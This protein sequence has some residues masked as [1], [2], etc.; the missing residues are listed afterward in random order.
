MKKLLSI[1]LSMVCVFVGVCFSGCEKTGPIPNGKYADTPS[2][3]ISYYTEDHG[4]EFYWEVKGDEAWH[5]T[6]NSLDYKAE[7]EKGENGEI[8]FRGYKWKSFLS[9]TQIG[10]ET[11]YVV[12]YNET[13]K[14]I[15]V[16][17]LQWSICDDAQ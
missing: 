12:E 9:S 6:S 16:E 11:D 10:S 7:I 3:N 5:Y 17:I 2:G 15:T 14:S 1:I 8:Y 4:V 13:E